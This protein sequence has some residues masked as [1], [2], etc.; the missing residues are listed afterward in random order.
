LFRQEMEPD[1]RG[2]KEQ[3]RLEEDP[4]LSNSE[5]RV[6]NRVFQTGGNNRYSRI[7]HAKQMGY[8][9]RPASSLPSH[10]CSRR[11]ATVSML[12]LQWSLLQLQRNAVWSFNGSENHYQ[13]PLA[14]NSRGREAIQIENLR[15]RR[16]DY[17]PELESY[18]ITTRNIT[19]NEDSTRVWLDDHNGQE[20]DQSHA[21]SR[22]LGLAVE[23]E[24]NDNVNDNISK[25]RSL[26]IAKTSDGA[27]QVKETH[28]NKKFGIGNWRNPMC[29]S[30]IQTRRASHQVALKVEGQGSSQQ[31][32]EQ[33][34]STQQERDTRHNLV[35]QQ[36][37]AQSTIVLHETQQ[38]DN[39]PDRCFE[40]RMG[41]TLIR[42]NQEKVFAYGDW[43]DNNLK[44]SN[45]REVRAV[46]KA[47]LEFRQE[48]T[49]QQ[50]I[51]IRL[52]TDNTV[53]MYRFNKGKGSITIAPQVD[54]VLKF[55]EQYNW[56]LY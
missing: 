16:R 22:V 53:T 34:D 30:T 5:Q 37:S 32:L 38:V 55:A 6:G 12:Q 25:E 35:D 44:S 2:P 20:P 33:V 7:I 47:L 40:F 23:H 31:K 51:G 27:S 45:Q 43:K 17:D 18:N 46:L 29:K 26:E 54:K 13:M 4:G 11:D 21:D 50:P 48:L 42:D 49:Q 19:S 41:A 8:N 3:R 1:I 56:T 24:S 15:L 28:K 52:L 10:Q 9:N 39:N 14:S 36:V